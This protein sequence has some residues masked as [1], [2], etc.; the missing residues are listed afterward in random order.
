MKHS[1]PA[2]VASY[3]TG[4]LASGTLVFMRDDAQAALGIGQGAFLDAAEKLQKRSQLF[5][6]RRGFYVAVPPQYLNWGSPPPAWFVDDLMRYERTPYYVALLKAAELHGAAH[7]AVMEFQ[8]VATKQIPVIQAGRSRITFTFRKDLAPVAAGIDEL[9]TDT[10][11]MKVSSPELTILDLLRYPQAGGGMDTIATVLEELGPKADAE[12]LSALC[13]AF[14]RSVV[15]RAGY[16][17]GK[18][19]LADHA[20]KVHAALTGGRA[21]QWVELDPALAGDPDLAPAVVERD[22]RWRVI[23]RHMPE[24]DE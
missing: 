5:S 14:E 6:P 10:G 19:G 7:Q 18:A 15:Q 2:S 22:T 17:L 23:V 8:V 9:K 16:L 11:R 4:L 20:D 21:A 13:P 24:R 3:V 1:Q 12:K